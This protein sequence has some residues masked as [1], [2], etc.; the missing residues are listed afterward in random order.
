MND[1]DYDPFAESTYEC[2]DCGATVETESASGCPDC[3]GT[4]RNK[5]LPME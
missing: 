1:P 2:L 4:L 5:A 3:G